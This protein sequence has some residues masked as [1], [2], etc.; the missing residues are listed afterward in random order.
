MTQRMR[1][2]VMIAGALAAAGLARVAGAA[3]PEGGMP[4]I[5]LVLKSLSDPFT[6][7][8][9][10][11]ARNYQQHYASQ[12]V[13]TVRG[14]ATEPDTAGQ[15][16]IV[17][18]M[19]GAKMNAIVIAPSGS[20]GLTAVV[21]RAIKA[22]I[23]VISI[24]N[25]LDDALQEAAKISVPFV[26]PDNRK[27]AMLVA[28]YLA[29][30]L[31]PGD[32]VGIIGGIQADRNAQQRN[33]GYKEAM[34]AAGMQVVATEPGDWEYGKGRDVASRMLGQ[35]PQIRGLLCA[36]DNMAMGAADAVRDAGRTGGVLITGYNAID[37]IKPLIADGHVLATV[38][39]FA[40]R[41]AVFGMDVALKAVTE[42]RKQSELSRTIETPL[43]LVTAAKR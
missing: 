32:Q 25:P 31:K 6:V 23:I 16:R 5:A 15:I 21:A 11:A 19:I 2:R 43:Q 8:M 13:L 40:E 12:F 26:G 42:Q 24:D 17:E 20:K 39:Q 36:N 41:Q 33:S 38:N 1:R 4:K 35:H 22:G 3:T 18:E 37:A 30:R 9:A 29:E 34:S 27:G 14:T 28:N 7:A 10:N